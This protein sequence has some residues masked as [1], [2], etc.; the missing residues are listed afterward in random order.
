MQIKL[1]CRYKLLKSIRCSWCPGVIYCVETSSLTFKERHVDQLTGLL[2]LIFHGGFRG[3]EVTEFDFLDVSLSQSVPTWANSQICCCSS[4][5]FLPF[6]FWERRR[7]N[8]LLSTLAQ[9]IIVCV[10]KHG[11]NY[12]VY[13]IIEIK[14]KVL[15][16]LLDKHYPMSQHVNIYFIFE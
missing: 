6:T 1:A 2:V 9:W 13:K 15:Q 5:F 10:G 8:L 7:D 16:I 11:N 14:A 3:H 12:N 4:S